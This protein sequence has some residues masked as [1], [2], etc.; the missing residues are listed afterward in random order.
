MRENLSSMYEIVLIYKCTCMHIA[1]SAQSRQVHNDNKNI[2]IYLQK[3]G[4]IIIII[5]VLS[6]NFENEITLIQCIC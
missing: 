4:V 1:Q 2:N 5:A 6:L 3:K